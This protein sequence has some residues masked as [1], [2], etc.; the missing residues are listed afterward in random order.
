[1]VLCPPLLRRMSVVLP[2]VIVGPVALIRVRV[3]FVAVLAT[4]TKVVLRVSNAVATSTTT[5]GVMLRMMRVAWALIVR[6]A[7]LVPL[8]VMSVLL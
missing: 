7:V 4:L 2:H 5:I 6:I 8:N 1:M 3:L